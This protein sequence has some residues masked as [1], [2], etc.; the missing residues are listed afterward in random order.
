MDKLTV[1]EERFAFRVGDDLFR[2]VEAAD[3]AADRLCLCLILGQLAGVALSAAGVTGAG[4][5][6]ALRAMR[7]MAERFAAQ[8][9]GAHAVVD[10][11]L[12]AEGGHA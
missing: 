12:A 5:V 7:D 8:A 4:R 2:R 10:L 11:V 6:E 3:I 9:D 1:T